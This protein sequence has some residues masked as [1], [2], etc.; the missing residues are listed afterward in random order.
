MGKYLPSET[1]HDE[2]RLTKM[3]GDYLH[4]AAQK[5]SLATEPGSPRRNTNGG[6]KFRS[7]EVQSAQGEASRT[8]PSSQCFSRSGSPADFGGRVRPLFTAELSPFSSRGY[9]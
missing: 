9:G 6:E 5:N 1:L 2:D 7:P 3:M 4:A 8:L